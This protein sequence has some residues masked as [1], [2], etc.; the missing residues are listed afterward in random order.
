MYSAPQFA[1]TGESQMAQ[2]QALYRNSSG[3][4]SGKTKIFE[5]PFLLDLSRHFA[6]IATADFMLG[7]MLDLAGLI[8]L[9]AALCMVAS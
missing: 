5:R 7:E 2:T 9:L 1:K 3:S 8:V 6:V 4:D